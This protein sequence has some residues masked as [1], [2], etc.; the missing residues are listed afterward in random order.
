[1]SDPYYLT[2]EQMARLEQIFPKVTASHGLMIG[3]F[4]VAMFSSAATG[5]ADAMPLGRMVHTSMS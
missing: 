3:G 1:M 4:Y 2:K 5:C